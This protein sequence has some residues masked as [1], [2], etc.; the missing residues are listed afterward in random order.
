MVPWT[1]VFKWHKR[2][3]SGYKKKE[4]DHRQESLHG[5]LSELNSRM[6]KNDKLTLLTTMD[7]LGQSKIDA[8]LLLHDVGMK[9]VLAEA[10][11]GANLSLYDVE[12]K[13]VLAEA[14]IDASLWLHDVG[15]K[16]VLAEAGIGTNL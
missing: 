10:K 13:K 4:D 1:Q 2:F 5:P 6:L 7:E 9:K 14:G 3:K 15:M 12:M 8:N 11:I 16:K